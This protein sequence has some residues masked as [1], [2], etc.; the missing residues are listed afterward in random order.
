MVCVL[1]MLLG[2]VLW[3]YTIGSV[4]SM[5]SN[6]SP[7]ESRYEASTDLLNLAMREARVPHSER[8]MFREYLRESKAYQMRV[9]FGKVAETFSP[10]LQK[11]LIYHMT[12]EAMET[13]YYFIDP[14]APPTFLEDVASCLVPHFFSPREPLDSLRSCLCLLD[15]GTIA[16]GG[17]I[18]VPPSVFHEDFIITQQKYQRVIS[19]TSMTYAQVL[20]LTR[21]A[22]EDILD[23]HPKFAPKIRKAAAKMAFCRA[24]KLTVVIYRKWVAKMPP[25]TAL[26]LREA[27]D[28]ACEGNGFA[29]PPPSTK[30]R[31]RRLEE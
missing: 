31:I 23:M 13:V 3:A 5:L 29:L 18:K 16:H 22:M 17:V 10:M 8:Q 9:E 28:E 14:E 6:S 30:A 11:H 25:G 20:V 2:G 21:A 12:K 7:V 4:C 24:V 19:T 1:F 26:S 15:R 27:F